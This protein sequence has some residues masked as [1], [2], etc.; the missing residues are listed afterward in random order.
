MSFQLEDSALCEL[1][2]LSAEAGISQP[3]AM[4]TRRTNAF[5]DPALRDAFLSGDMEKLRRAAEAD[6]LE[7]SRAAELFLDVFVYERTELQAAEDIVDVG[8]FEFVLP[9]AL[10]SFLAD[11]CLVYRGGFA[12]LDSNGAEI[13]LPF[14]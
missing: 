14:G 8:S 1:R 2:R 13:D 3:V 11:C 9:P 7:S 4:L 5:S 10:A 12:L 6:W